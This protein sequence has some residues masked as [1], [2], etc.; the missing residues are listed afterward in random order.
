MPTGKH[1]RKGHY[2]SNPRRRK[3]ASGWGVAAVIALV[4]LVVVQGRTDDGD[5]GTQPGSVIPASAPPA[6]GGAP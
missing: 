5:Q 4:A 3:H 2:V 6:D 1:W